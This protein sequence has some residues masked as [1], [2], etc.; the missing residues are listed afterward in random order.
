[1]VEIHKTNE[2]LQIPLYIHYEGAISY[3]GAYLPFYANGFFF[4]EGFK[5]Y[6]GV[7]NRPK[8]LMGTTVV[9][10]TNMCVAAYSDKAV[11]HAELVRLLENR[12]AKNLPRRLGEVISKWKESANIN[13]IDLWKTSIIM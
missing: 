5:F 8:S 7:Y 3:S 1:M 4:Y 6:L 11:P 13:F 12:I 2:V 10:A 9:E